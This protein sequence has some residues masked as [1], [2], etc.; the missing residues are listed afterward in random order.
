MNFVIEPDE[1][2]D[3]FK[4]ALKQNPSDPLLASKLGRAYVKTHQYTKAIAYYKEATLTDENSALKLDLAELFLKLKQFSN[5]EQVLVNEIDATKGNDEDLTMLQTRTKQLLLL[6]R[7]RE[8]SS[9][10]N[11]SL[12]TLKEARDNQYRLQKRISLE[13]TGGM[14]EQHKILTKCGFYLYFFFFLLTGNCVNFRLFF[15]VEFVFLWL[16]KR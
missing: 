14:Q 16:N 5:A 13:Q 6:A 15:I 7:I 3:A 2:I 9:Y 11:S 8:K 1:A 4:Q 12:S 10:L